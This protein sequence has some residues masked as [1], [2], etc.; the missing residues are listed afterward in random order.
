MLPRAARG[1][2]GDEEATR[3]PLTLEKKKEIVAEYKR[4]ENDT[5]SPEVQV[6]L[7]SE[8]IRQLQ[9]HLEMHKKDFHT[10]RGPSGTGRGRLWASGGWPPRARAPAGWPGQ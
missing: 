4:A 6:A 5:G 7:F 9:G 10:R 8:R 1:A 2:E 3:L